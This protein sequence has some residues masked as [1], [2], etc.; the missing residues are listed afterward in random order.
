[1]AAEAVSTE[2]GC[3]VV[4]VG[5]AG[6]LDPRVTFRVPLALRLFL[7]LPVLR[8]LPARVIG[9]GFKRVHVKL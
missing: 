1:M 2:A 8:T 9:L 3:A 6:A 4:V 5:P 7:R